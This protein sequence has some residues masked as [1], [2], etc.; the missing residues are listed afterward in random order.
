ML[1]SF[2]PCALGPVGS[3]HRGTERQ[4]E[5]VPQAKPALVLQVFL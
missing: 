2:A 4:R 1:G 3:W 5:F